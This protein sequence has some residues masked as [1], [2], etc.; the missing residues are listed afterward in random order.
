VH[1]IRSSDQFCVA[2]RHVDHAVWEKS[3]SRGSIGV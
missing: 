1:N 2:A 3:S